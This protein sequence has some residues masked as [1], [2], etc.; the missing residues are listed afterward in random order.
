MHRRVRCWA[1]SFLFPFST[2]SSPAWQCQRRAPVK[3]CR[4]VFAVCSL[5]PPADAGSE[6]PLLSPA[7]ITTSSARWDWGSRA[8]GAAAGLRRAW[9]QSGSVGHARGNLRLSEA[10]KVATPAP[11]RRARSSSLYWG[12]GALEAWCS[13]RRSVPHHFVWRDGKTWVNRMRRMRL[14][15]L[16]A[17]GV[18]DAA[19]ATPFRFQQSCRLPGGASLLA[20]PCR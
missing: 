8:V 18:P 3:Q 2:V 6:L 20:A 13:A 17:I 5:L 11:H 7:P 14:F 16:Q 19:G 9:K 15:H 1:A 12:S 10:S 4:R